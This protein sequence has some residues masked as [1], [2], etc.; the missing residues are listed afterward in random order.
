M[1]VCLLVCFPFRYW[2]S[3]KFSLG[4]EHLTSNQMRFPQEGDALLV[5]SIST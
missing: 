4:T 3:F 1:F 2:Q 5:R